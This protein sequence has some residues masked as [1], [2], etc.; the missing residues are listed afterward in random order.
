MENFIRKLS[1]TEPHNELEQL[2]KDLA[3]K[4]AEKE[5]LENNN[6]V[7]AKNIQNLDKTDPNYNQKKLEQEGAIAAANATIKEKRFDILI[8]ELN[9][10]IAGL[11]KALESE[12]LVTSRAESKLRIILNFITFH[13]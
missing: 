12:F 1:K 9:Q 4:L 13:R 2:E 10:K 7:A 6:R 11:K 3:E 8:A 5:Q